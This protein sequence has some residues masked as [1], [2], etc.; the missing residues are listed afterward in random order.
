MGF[1]VPRDGRRF[2][3]LLAEQPFDVRGV[4]RRREI[5]P[6]PLAGAIEVGDHKVGLRSQGVGL[7]ELRA[8]SVR[9]LVARLRPGLPLRDPVRIGERE[10]RTGVV[11]V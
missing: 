9:Q 6:R 2:D 5:D 8:P 4:D 1:V 7:E 3:D 10:Q 11:Q